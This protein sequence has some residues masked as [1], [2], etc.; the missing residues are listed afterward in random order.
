VVAEAQV[1]LTELRGME[2][3][4]SFQ[5]QIEGLKEAIDTIQSELSRTMTTRDR[6][7]A[8]TGRLRAEGADLQARH[9]ALRAETEELRALGAELEARHTALQ[10]KTVQLRALAADLQAR[11]FALRAEFAAATRAR[12]IAEQD[13]AH[14]LA[15]RSWRWTMPLRALAAASRR[16]MQ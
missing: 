12:A 4:N 2:S 13:H 1:A 5:V 14:V 7:Q 3:R 8:E 11:N 6:L 16:W 15:S 9:A 10:V